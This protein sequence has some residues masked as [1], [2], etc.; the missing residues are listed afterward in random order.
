MLPEREAQP[1]WRIDASHKP[2]SLAVGAE[3]ECR[4]VEALPS[5]VGQILAVNGE[6]EPARCLGNV[7]QPAT[8]RAEHRMTEANASPR[9]P[10]NS[11]QIHPAGVGV[12]SAVGDVLAI[13]TEHGAICVNTVIRPCYDA[14]Q[15]HRRPGTRSRHVCEMRAMRAEAQRSQDAIKRRL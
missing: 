14:I 5:V 13:G 8:G 9:R 6:H 12:G 2:D 11:V 10:R 15:D 7:C 4:G 1:I 3:S